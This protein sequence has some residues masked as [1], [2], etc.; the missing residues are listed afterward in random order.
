[1]SAFT[2]LFDA[3]VLYPA[4]IRDLLLELARSDLFRAKWTE[5]IN[6]EWIRNVLQDRP[7]LTEAQLARTRMLMNASVLDCLV[8]D[9]EPLIEALALPD[10]DDRHVLAAAIKGRADVIVT[11]NLTDF[12]IYCLDNYGIEAQHPDVFIGHLIDL[13]DGKVC[14]AVRQVRARLR[15]PPL[16]VFEYL[17]KLERCGLAVTAVTLR[18]MHTY[19]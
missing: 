13:S 9:Y 8:K 11:F 5:Q 3:N 4:Q 19:L 6:D 15:Q 18:E 17:E 16:D 7:D 2:A 14:A 10:P 1:M 12:P